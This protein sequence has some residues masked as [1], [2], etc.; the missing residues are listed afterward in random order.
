MGVRYDGCGWFSLGG[1][2]FELSI[3]GFAVADGNKTLKRVTLY[4]GGFLIER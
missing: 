3:F 4:V 2:T 1:T